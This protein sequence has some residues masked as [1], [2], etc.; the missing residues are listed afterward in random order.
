MQQRPLLVLVLSTLIVETGFLFVQ[1]GASTPSS[2][3]LEDQLFYPHTSWT[4]SFDLVPVSMGISG[5]R[6]LR[7]GWVGNGRRN[8]R[9]GT[10][11][12]FRRYCFHDGQRSQRAFLF[13]LDRVRR[14]VVFGRG[15]GTDA[16]RIPPSQS[17]VPFL[18]G[19]GLTLTNPASFSHLVVSDAE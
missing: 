4:R 9:S 11:K 5:L 7:H 3:G 10:G 16:S 13:L 17:S 14:T 12:G 1:N 15:P 6:L 8:D 2:H 19:T 18:S